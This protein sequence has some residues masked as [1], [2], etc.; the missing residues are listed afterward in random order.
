MGHGPGA[1][2]ADGYL[3]LP[4][5]AGKGDLGLLI[6]ILIMKHQYAVL[7]QAVPDRQEC[8]FIHGLA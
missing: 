5:M 3:Q 8:R 6:Q 1:V 4:K 7:V 2:A